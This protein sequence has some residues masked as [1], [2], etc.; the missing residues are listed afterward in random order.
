MASNLVVSLVV[1]LSNLASSGLKGLAADTAKAGAAAKTTAKA[2][3]GLSADSAKAVKPVKDVG[4]ATK[5]L[6][7]PSAQ[8]AAAQD[9]VGYSMD[10]V[11][12]RARAYG[13][14]VKRDIIDSLKA[15][16]AAAGLAAIAV[17]GVATAMLG[18]IV[19]ATGWVRGQSQAAIAVGRA[20]R[21]AG[22]G[23]EA[24]QKL[25]YAFTRAG[26]S[27]GGFDTSV[28]SLTRSMVAAQKG[29]PDQA[30]AFRRLGISVR[31]ANNHYKSADALLAEVADGMARLK[32]GTV[33]AKIAQVLFNEQG[34]VMIA[35]T[36]KGSAGL[37][38]MG[39]EAEQ[40]GLILSQKTIRASEK[41]NSVWERGS[42]TIRGAGLAIFSVLLPPL[43]KLVAKVAD[44]IVQNKDDILK[45]ITKGIDWLSA[46]LPEILKGLG[47]F[48]GLIKD[49]IVTSVKFTKAVGGIGTI[50]DGLAVLLAGQVAWS[51]ITVTAAIWGFNAALYAFP[52]TWIIAGITAVAVGAY[53]IIRHWDVVK[54]WLGNFW[55]WL[56]ENFMALGPMVAPFILAAKL[57]Q[58]NWG[59]LTATFEGLWNAITGGF[60]KISAA[61]NALPPGVREFLKFGASISFPGGALVAA[62]MSGAAQP[63]AAAAPSRS[64]QNAPPSASPQK[65]Q[66]S[67]KIDASGLPSDMRITPVSSDPNMPIE[68][69]RGSIFP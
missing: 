62:G 45:G 5:D 8:A 31:D 3:A 25:E 48:V 51:L 69:F 36:E 24:Y 54:T 53:L 19:A 37:K 63:S 52:G 15:V 13:R 59:S 66:A 39:D 26:G 46:H 41:F 30:A 57:I 2:T 49:I 6:V 12:R 22:V 65:V 21:A 27:A 14:M 28:Q 4:K 29:T 16:P 23:V 32:D 34:A 61:W 35:M 55:T 60:D 38:A 58:E 1:K 43:T 68:L 11:G 44:L 56:K 17:A 20:A 67:L 47:D 33:K 9:K 18:G 7:A 10:R 50:L 40:A 64:V 42:R